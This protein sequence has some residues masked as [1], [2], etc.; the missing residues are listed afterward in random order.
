M[1]SGT[2]FI[3]TQ[4]RESDVRTPLE[5]DEVTADEI[6]RMPDDLDAYPEPGATLMVV[7]ANPDA[8]RE[9]AKRIAVG[10]G[11]P[12]DGS[13]RPEL[14]GNIGVHAYTPSRRVPVIIR[15]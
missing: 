10:M 12:D 7:H 11:M 2:F 6:A 15:R 5:Y 14:W 8:A 9:A 1:A 4:Q 13:T 3:V